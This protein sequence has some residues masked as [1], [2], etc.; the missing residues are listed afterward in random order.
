MTL[1]NT[2]DYSMWP[3]SPRLL[4]RMP[5]LQA[6]ATETFGK[7]ITVTGGFR[8]PVHHHVREQLT[9]RESQHLHG[10]ATDYG[11]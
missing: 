8:N 11:Q 2:R 6:M 3:A 7:P 9:P 1:R 4:A 5:I 10:A